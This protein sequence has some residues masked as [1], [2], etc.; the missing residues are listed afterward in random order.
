MQHIQ[1]KLARQPTYWA[2]I[3]AD[4][5]TRES[6]MKEMC[7]SIRELLIGLILKSFLNQ[8]PLKLKDDM[9]DC[10]SLCEKS[11]KKTPVH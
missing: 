4:K 9:H 1:Q 11:N 2:L 6:L 3:T 8:N 7:N 10:S 5:V